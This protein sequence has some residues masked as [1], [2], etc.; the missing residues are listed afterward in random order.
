MT[1]L[2]LQQKPR[3]SFEFFPAKT[4]AGIDKLIQVRD[5]LNELTPDFF[6]ITYGAGGSTRDTTQEL[7]TRFRQDGI[8]T[9]PHLSFGGNNADSMVSLLQ[10]YKD[11]GVNRIVALRGDIPTDQSPTSKTLYASDLVLFIRKIFGDH[12]QLEV[13]AYPEVHPEAS[14][15]STDINYLKM[16]FIAGADSAITQYFFNEDAYF[17]FMDR[18]RKA[19]IDQPIY[20]GIMPIINHRNL[21]RFSEA[22]GTEIPRWLRKSLDDYGND[23]HSL[24]EFGIEF[25]TKMCERLL[26]NGAPG[27][28]FFTMNQSEHVKRVIDNLSI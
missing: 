27:L 16:K 17:R 1:S 14:S 28:H 7:V 2:S 4:A 8:N 25:L 21:Y 5:K 10:Q 3:L 26:K 13:A 9:A 18:C 11:A 6:S 15:Y 23:S 22:C 24:T 19:G 20:P 12:F